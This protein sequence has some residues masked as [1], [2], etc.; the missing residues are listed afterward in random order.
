METQ[1][2]IPLEEALEEAPKLVKA[3]RKQYGDKVTVARIWDAPHFILAIEP[4][5]TT[6]VS[7]LVD[8]KEIGIYEK[9][10]DIDGTYAQR[11]N[12]ELIKH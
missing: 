12:D 10:W 5:G 3:L 8:G 1:S 4:A 11:Y 6:K 2:Q 9:D 7:I